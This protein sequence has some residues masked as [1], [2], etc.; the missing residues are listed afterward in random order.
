MFLTYSTYRLSNLPIEYFDPK[1]C[2]QHLQE[3][4]KKLLCAY[5][6]CDLNQTSGEYD[7]S[8]RIIIESIYIVFNLGATEAI[9][10]ALTVPIS[11]K[12]LNFII[13]Y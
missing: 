6:D 9:I 4:L 11:I 2:N 7:T 8:K 1:I 12:K 3:C 10:R 5:D 13:L